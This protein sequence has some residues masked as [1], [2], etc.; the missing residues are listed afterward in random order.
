MSLIFHSC[1]PY[2]LSTWSLNAPLNY[3]TDRNLSIE[4][5]FHDLMSDDGA[6]TRQDCI[7]CTRAKGKE[8]H[9]D[10]YNQVR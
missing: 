3:P 8:I 4:D 5:V 1:P 10:T 6:H 7:D 2:F 9:Y